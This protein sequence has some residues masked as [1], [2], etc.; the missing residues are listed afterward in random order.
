M[1][2]VLF[3]LVKKGSF[4]KI[5]GVSLCI[6]VVCLAYNLPTILEVAKQPMADRSSVLASAKDLRISQDNLKVITQ[7]MNYHLQDVDDSVRL[8]LL[9]KFIPQGNTYLYQGRAIANFVSL[10]GIRDPQTLLKE[11][12]LTYIPMWTSKAIMSKVLDG[13]TVKVSFSDN[14][15][16]YM[17]DGKPLG[18][19][20]SLK[21]SLLFDRGIT[22]GI[23]YPV[24]DN[25]V[26]VGYL[27]FL[28]RDVQNVSGLAKSLGDRL[29]HYIVMRTE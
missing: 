25:G 6:I 7:Y 23:I 22:D 15:F 1:L 14:G 2:K 26:V 3:L 12:G 5:F 18:D 13:E 11:A 9:Y 21:F 19:T 16:E 10:R 20:P 29:A 24:F 28:G 4:L 27:F 8:V 17:D